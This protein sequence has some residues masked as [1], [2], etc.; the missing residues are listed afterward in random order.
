MNSTLRSIDRELECVAAEEDELLERKREATKR[1]L[2]TCTSCRRKNPLG[3]WVFIQRRGYVP[4]RGCTE[5]DYWYN[6]HLAVCHIRCPR[7]GDENYLHAHPDRNRLEELFGNDGFRLVGH[8]RSVET[9]SD[10][11]RMNY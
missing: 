11:Q 3:Q 8:F 5:G 9:R 6:A 10:P 1:L 7:C 4:P 2:L